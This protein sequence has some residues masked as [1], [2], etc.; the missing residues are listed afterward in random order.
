VSQPIT[1]LAGLAGTGSPVAD[2]H[3]RTPRGKQ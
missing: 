1:G 2:E 3:C